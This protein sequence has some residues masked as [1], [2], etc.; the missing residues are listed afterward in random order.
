MRRIGTEKERFGSIS[1]KLKRFQTKAGQEFKHW[2]T[3]YDSLDDDL[4]EGTEGVDDM[5][6]YPRIYLEYQVVSSQFTSMIN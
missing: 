6:D 2:V 1:F 3:L 4:F 5:F